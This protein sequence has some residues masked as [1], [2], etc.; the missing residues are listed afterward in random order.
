MDL[1]RVR[2][3][4]VLSSPGCYPREFLDGLEE[5]IIRRHSQNL[6]KALSGTGGYPLQYLLI[7]SYHIESAVLDGDQG[8][9]LRLEE[10]VEPLREIRGVRLVYIR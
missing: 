3:L 2:M 5:R 10:M 8:F 6:E 7:E 9:G 4:H 1:K